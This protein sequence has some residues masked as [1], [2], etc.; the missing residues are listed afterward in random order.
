[1]NEIPEMMPDIEDEWEYYD[2][3]ADEK[4]RDT[5][6]DEAKEALMAELFEKSPGKV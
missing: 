3:V 2:E 6:I 5:K 1:M 4:P